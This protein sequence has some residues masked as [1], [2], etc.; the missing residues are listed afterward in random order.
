M[1]KNKIFKLIKEIWVIATL[2]TIG[3]A[4]ILYFWQVLTTDTMPFYWF[5]SWVFVSNV[6]T[7]CIAFKSLLRK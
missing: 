3:A 7:G 4:T 2:S 6:V 5:V 1:L